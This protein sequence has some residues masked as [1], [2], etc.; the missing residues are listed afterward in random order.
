MCVSHFFALLWERN[1]SFLR[2][3]DQFIWNVARRRN[4]LLCYY[5]SGSVILGKEELFCILKSKMKYNCIKSPSWKC[6]LKK[7]LSVKKYFDTIQSKLTSEVAKLSSLKS[8]VPLHLCC[9]N[10]RLNLITPKFIIPSS[11]QSKDR[12][13]TQCFGIQACK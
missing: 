10:K 13:T 4:V 9:P 7:K 6:L 12:Y 8:E 11:T 3:L 5:L 1:K 2:G